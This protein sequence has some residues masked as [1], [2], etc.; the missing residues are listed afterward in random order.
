MAVRYG[1]FSYTDFVAAAH[2]QP[3]GPNFQVCS[4]RA[5]RLSHQRPRTI[6]QRCGV[7][8]T[9]R[10]SDHLGSLMKLMKTHHFE[11]SIRVGVGKEAGVELSGLR[12]GLLKARTEG[13]RSCSLKGGPRS[14]ALNGGAEG[15]RSGSL[16]ARAEGCRARSCGDG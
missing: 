9:L 16:K 15:S 6:S 7:C 12:A 2:F 3:H 1:S 14:G 13:P 11:T 5:L 8:F 10:L 4:S